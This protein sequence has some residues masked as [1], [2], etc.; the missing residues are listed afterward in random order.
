MDNNS[1]FIQGFYLDPV[2]SG[3]PF[4]DSLAVT[5]E[6]SFRVLDFLKQKHHAI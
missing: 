5:S 6:E 2:L 4:K 1:R 3:K